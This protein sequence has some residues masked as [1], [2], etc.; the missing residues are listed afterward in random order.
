MN[1]KFPIL[2]RRLCI[3]LSNRELTFSF[4]NN[5]FACT[6]Q[7]KRFWGLILKENFKARKK[8]VR[9]EIMYHFKIC[10]MRKLLFLLL[11]VIGMASC[12]N[13][14]YELTSSNVLEWVNQLLRFHLMKLK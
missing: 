4:L 7:G 2:N 6:K 13:D 10:I 14:C 9:V 8:K 1:A 3:W 5:L 11:V 12:N